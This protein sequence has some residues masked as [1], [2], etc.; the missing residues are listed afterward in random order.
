[1]PGYQVSVSKSRGCLL[2]LLLVIVTLS[3]LA[4]LVC[5]LFWKLHFDGGFTWSS[6]PGKQFAWHP[7]LLTFSIVLMG[8]G[9]IM[10]R[11]TPRCISRRTSKALHA[12]VMLLSLA[13]AII[14]LWA[15]FESH[16]LASPPIPNMFSLHSWVGISTLGF[17]AVQLAFGLLIFLFPCAPSRVRGYYHPLHIFFGLCMLA[18]ATA[19]ALIG[20]TEE[21]LFSLS[22]SYTTLPGKG[23][24][25][26]CLGM[27]LSVFTITIMFIATKAGFKQLD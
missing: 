13:T 24:L 3:G 12:M 5:V 25:L 23:V 22:S 4:S 17:F 2:P 19:A 11:I 26:N 7:L 14:G 27:F 1:M 9:S 8:L 15:V 21:A 20:I 6:D 10:Y 16:D 18:S